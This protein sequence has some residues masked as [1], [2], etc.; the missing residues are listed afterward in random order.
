MFLRMR[1]EP[2]RTAW[3]G[4]HQIAL[5]LRRSLMFIDGVINTPMALQRSAM[6]PAM[7][8]DTRLMFRSYGA[9]RIFGKLVL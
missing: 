7:L 8:R 3:P 5:W 9:G 1:S 6:F 4:P 2:D